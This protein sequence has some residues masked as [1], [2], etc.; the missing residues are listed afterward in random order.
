MEKRR[1]GVLGPSYGKN[2]ILFVDDLNMPQKEKY[3][4][5]PP[6]EL[7]RQWMDYSGWYN[8]NSPEREFTRIEGVR[9]MGA[10]GPPGN[11]RNSISSRYIRH[12]NVLYIEPYSS[13]SLKY[14]FS[15]IMDWL[16]LS[17]A[18]PPFPQAVQSM[19]ESV[20]SNTI[21][22]YG[23]VSAAFKPTP[24]KS[25]YT[26][27]LRDVSKVFQGIAKSSGKGIQKEDDMLKLW[28]HE[29]IRVFQDRLINNDDRGQFQTL[30]NTLIKEKFKKDWNSLVQ[31]EPLIFGSFVQMCYPNGDTTLKP[32]KDVYCE[33][34]DREKLSKAVEAQLADF[35]SMNAAKKMNLVLFEAA[36]EHTAKITRIISTEFGH[37]LLM[38]VGGSGRKSLT[39]LAVH[40]ALF[41]TFEIEITKAYD[42]KEWRNNMRNILFYQ[43]G[44]EEKKMVFV[45]NDTQIII[46][47]FL[48][49]INNIL[50]NGEIP[51]LYQDIEDI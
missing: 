50:N 44:V 24:A 12:F 13:D 10:M 36:I 40:I 43:C 31:V 27:N 9:F 18:S 42:F 8:I 32:Y 7:L 6:I 19:K 38:G 14:I 37:A 39:N 28:A 46:E 51:N 11:G 17:K 35:N 1:K 20:V 48:E 29:C 15:T 45:L 21:E 47:A 49:D 4:A 25:H 41:E 22:I 23:R 33:L 2:G 16:F 34:S 30:L 26:Y 5:Q 3:G